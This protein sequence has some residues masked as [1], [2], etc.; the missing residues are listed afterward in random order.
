[1]DLVGYGNE[2]GNQMEE[3]GICLLVGISRISLEMLMTEDR[4]TKEH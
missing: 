1:M 4:R 2:P 3:N